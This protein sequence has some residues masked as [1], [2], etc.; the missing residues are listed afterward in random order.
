MPLP[1]F[2]W[3]FWWK[4][5]LF[6]PYFVCPWWLYCC[7]S[8][9]SLNKWW[10]YSRMDSVGNYIPPLIN[11]TSAVSLPPFGL[12]LI[13]VGGTFSDV[14]SQTDHNCFFIIVACCS[15]AKTWQTWKK[16]NS[17]GDH[18]TLHIS[19]T[20]THILISPGPPVPLVLSMAKPPSGWVS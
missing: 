3:T 12:E 10:M 6:L 17:R 5:C 4:S 11:M 9:L 8:P 14:L 18:F 15:T 13:L 1:K 2:L 7:S 16:K 20:N 19:N